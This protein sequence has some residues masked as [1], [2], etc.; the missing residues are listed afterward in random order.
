MNI[1][2]TGSTGFLG[3]NVLE[4]L[5]KSPHTIYILSHQKDNDRKLSKNII[6]KKGDISNKFSLIKIKKENPEIEIL[7]HIAALVPRTKKEDNEIL[8]K[9]INKIHY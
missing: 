8:M 3:H 7:I 1:L 9:K 5:R 6:I 2:L 4:L